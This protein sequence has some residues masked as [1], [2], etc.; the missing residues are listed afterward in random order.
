[1][2]GLLVFTLFLSSGRSKNNRSNEDKENKSTKPLKA[3]FVGIFHFV[4]FNPENNG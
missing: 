1:M 2:L 3:L 4:N